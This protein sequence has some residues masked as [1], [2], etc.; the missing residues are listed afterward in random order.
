MCE[1]TQFVVYDLDTGESLYS[2]YRPDEYLIEEV[3]TVWTRAVNVVR[4]VSLISG[5]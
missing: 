5:R 3:N 4:L 1:A 2:L